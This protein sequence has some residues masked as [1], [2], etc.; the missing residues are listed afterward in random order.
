MII[1][2]FKPFLTQSQHTLTT[3]LPDDLPEV[4]LDA[5]RMEQVIINLLSNA[6]KYSYAGGKIHLKAVVENSTLRVDIKDEGSGI[7]AE[8]MTNLFKPYHRV[9]QD[10]KLPGLGLGLT[11]CKQIVEAHG[12]K[13]WADSQLGKGSTFSFRVPLVVWRD[14]D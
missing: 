8:D 9:E 4:E 13:I 2:R 3:E 1:T 5:S 10:R 6:G 7:S 11:I 14:A 12:G